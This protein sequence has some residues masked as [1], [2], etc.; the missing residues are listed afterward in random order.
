MKRDNEKAPAAAATTTEARENA[1]QDSNTD[2]APN[3][4]IQGSGGQGIIDYIPYGARNAVTGTELCKL[5]NCGPRDVTRAIQAARLH[6]APICSSNG[7][8]PGYYLTDDPGELERY[9]KSLDHRTR[10][11]TA[12]REA[13][14]V[15]RDGMSGQNRMEGF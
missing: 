7:D 10:E 12:T 4:I 9:I 13:L 2:P 15:T 8:V 5:M 14:A 3:D 6:G 11:M 1:S